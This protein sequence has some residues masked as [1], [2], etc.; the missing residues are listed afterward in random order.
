M[1]KIDEV[2]EQVIIGKT[3]VVP[4]LVQGALDEGSAAK[5]ILQAMIDGMKIVGDRFSSGD[6][7]VPEMLIAAKAMAK[8]V[9][10]LKPHLSADASTSLGTCIIGT[11]EGD[12]HDIGKNLVTMMIGSAGFDMVDLGVDQAPS[13]F[14]EAIINN[15]NVKLVACSALLTTTLPALNK[16]VDAIKESGL[17]GFKIMVGGAPVTQKFADEIRRRRVRAGCGI[18]RR[19]GKSNS[20]CLVYVDLSG[21]LSYKRKRET[22]QLICIQFPLYLYRRSRGIK[23][24]VPSSTGS[25]RLRLHKMHY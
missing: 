15:N 23:N 13:K 10:V 8:G 25:G 3:K 14:I 1:A 16:T 17:S 20:S 19:K 11:V 4:V 7:F 18:C 5:D 2:Q 6:I 9:D 24:G 21:F 22:S 12:L